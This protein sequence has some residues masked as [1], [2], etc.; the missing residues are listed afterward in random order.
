MLYVIEYELLAL[1][2]LVIVAL[3]FFYT[4]YFPSHQNQ[5]FG[6][7]I[8]VTVI[9]LF[10]DII[11][12]YTISHVFDMP[13]WINQLLNTLYYGIQ[14]FNP[15]LFLIY[16]LLLAGS[17]RI[18]DSSTVKL[19][20][21]PSA[22]I[23]FLLFFINPLTGM[24]FYIDPING[25]SYGVWFYCLHL[26]AFLYLA[27]TFFVAVYNKN[28]LSTIQYRTITMFIITIILTIILQARFPQYLIT[29]AILAIAV[30]IMYFTLQNPQE[31]KDVL[32][33]CFNYNAML[34]YLS[35]II[36]SKQS[37]HLIAININDLSRINRMFGLKNG[38]KVLIEIS[39]YLSSIN[40]D[41]WIFRMKGTRFVAIMH[42]ETSYHYFKSLIEKRIDSSWKIE[43]TEIVVSMS[44]CSMFK[45]Q[46]YVRSIDDVVN[47]IETSFV[48]SEVNGIKKKI[49]S[50]DTG[51][52]DE[53][54]R[55]IAVESALKNALETGNGLEL[56]F[57]PI[58]SV[59]KKS[60]TSAETLL[61]FSDPYLGSISPAE[62]VPIAEKNGLVLQMDLLVV[63]KVCEFITKYNPKETLG[64]EYISVN[65]SA[66]EF[67]N[68]QMPERMTEILNRYSINPDF[69]V[70]EITETV[71][72]VSYDIV[73]SCMSEY[74]SKGFRFALDDFGTGYANLSQVVDLPF[75]MVKIDRS[76][77]DGSITVLEDMLHMF[78][79]LG[80][81]T[82]VEG[83][84]TSTQSNLLESM[85]VDYI[86][87]YYH[88]HPLNEVHFIEFI[89]ISNFNI[90]HDID[91]KRQI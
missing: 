21:L 10:L 17:I 77:L 34:D 75:S 26:I 19:I 33:G 28:K 46:D 38:N 7:I 8:L 35:E 71:A 84:E 45:L 64:L 65:L 18:E 9:T 5:V 12:A 80:L 72:T 79:R 14:T 11:T 56:N 32:T 54:G 66:A 60:Y 42:S 90:N 41:T 74:R 88:A 62:F 51:L 85:E 81:S 37:F 31:M 49:I 25:Y 30:I 1:I 50:T 68:T 39:K 27:I 47:F 69:L 59:K 61:R 78:R 70:F 73:S 43:S 52:F 48:H 82:V 6:L 91:S 57:Q 4:K 13:F 87:G 76:L 83:V 16:T 29:G 89:N 58:Y 63:E 24:F 15:P 86:Q 67:M 44:V 23:L 53:L 36:K 40:D 55:M 3:K 2:A 20:F 22:I